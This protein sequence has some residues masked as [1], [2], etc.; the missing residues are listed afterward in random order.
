MMK[1][2]GTTWTIISAL[3]AV[4]AL[5]IPIALFMAGRQSK[6]LTLETISNAN[7]A[8]IRDPALAGLRLSYNDQPISHVSTTTIEVSNTGSQPIETRDFERPVVINYDKLTPIL[9][10]TLTERVPN[11]LMPQLISGPSSI[12]ISPLL[13]NPGDRFRINIVIGGEFKE[14][15]ID[16]RLAGV[17]AISRRL[18]KSEHR[19]SKAV[20]L[21]IV[22]AI[23]MLAYAYLGIASGAVL[24]RVPVSQM[25][26]GD[27]LAITLILGLASTSMAMAAL[28]LIAASRATTVWAYATGFFILI[29]GV[30][31][32]R[33]R[34]LR[35]QTRHQVISPRKK[36]A[37]KNAGAE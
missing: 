11:N 20:L 3:A 17:S 28:D 5:V 34:R 9:A 1:N 6:A 10:S 2:S 29:V 25:Q 8:D 13:L 23:T 12:T 36:G 14:P 26:R 33:A 19:S 18:L 35:L 4:A 27:A 30:V 15:E 31:L 7:V 22:G 32:G 21:F 37:G 16:A 24:P